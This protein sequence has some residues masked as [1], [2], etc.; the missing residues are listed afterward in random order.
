MIN[1]IDALMQPEKCHDENELAAFG[2]C[3]SLSKQTDRF[4]GQWPRR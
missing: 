3:V 4:Q 2:C 1:G